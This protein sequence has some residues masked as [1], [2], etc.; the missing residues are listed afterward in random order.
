MGRL[1]EFL[2]GRAQ[3][4]EV[5]HG[6]GG[7]ELLDEDAGLPVGALRNRAKDCR[8]GVTTA[9]RRLLGG[10]WLKGLGW[11]VQLARPLVMSRSRDS[12]ASLLL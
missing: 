10:A 7:R 1:L 9:G 11:L 2:Q 3:G 5:W 4:Q 8:D 6:S 12:T